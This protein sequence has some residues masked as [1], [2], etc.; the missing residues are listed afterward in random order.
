MEEMCD[1]LKKKK[2]LN[3]SNGKKLS[4]FLYMYTTVVLRNSSFAQFIYDKRIFEN[5]NIKLDGSGDGANSKFHS[6][7]FFYI[8]IQP[9]IC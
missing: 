3:S 7:I 8:Q 1:T 9:K 6:S 4:L 5:D 2:T